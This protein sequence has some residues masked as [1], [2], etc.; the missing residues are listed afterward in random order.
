MRRWRWWFCSMSEKQL[1]YFLLFSRWFWRLLTCRFVLVPIWWQTILQGNSYRQIGCQPAQPHSSSSCFVAHLH[2]ASLVLCSRILTSDADAVPPSQLR[3]RPSIAC[4]NFFCI[5][6]NCGEKQ[7]LIQLDTY[8]SFTSDA[9][10]AILT[11]RSFSP[12]SEGY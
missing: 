12:C 1:H 7:W 9:S 4:C 11:M 10:N 8:F 3:I 2:A 5:T 6:S